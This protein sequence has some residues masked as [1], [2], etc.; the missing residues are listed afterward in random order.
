MDIRG[1]IADLLTVHD[2]VIIPGLGGFIG[3]Y[4][5]ARIDPVYHAFQPPFKK[6]LFNVNLKQNDGLLASAVA[7]SLGTSYQDGCNLI[8]QFTEE[9]RQALLSGSR[10]I[11]PGIGQLH[12]GREGNIQFE[13]DK[14]FNLLA[15]SF[16]LGSFISPPVTRNGSLL[17]RD[18]MTIRGGMPAAGKRLVVPRVLKWAAILALPIGCAA[19]IGLTRYDKITVDAAS[20]A[21]IL[22][23]LF[24]RFSTASLVEK[25]EAPHKPAFAARITSAPV[26]QAAAPATQE[27][28]AVKEVP[29]AVKADDAFAVIV[30][31]FRLKEN[32][33]TC[34]ADL[35]RKGMDASIFDRS[36]TG[37]YRVAIGTCSQR[38]KADELLARTK[39]SDF[40]DAWL[41]AK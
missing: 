24:S 14:T 11:I 8:E 31:A 26:A 41:L 32:A 3:N 38:E 19:V 22:S 34:V 36:R 27:A 35:K 25:K 17:S 29:A 6:L 12:S 21:N 30:G 1:C 2:C 9:C 7:D 20:N 5:P 23:S 13:Q 37:L 18:Q 33:E 10:V 28:A 40:R 16:G 39:S 15:E 4:A